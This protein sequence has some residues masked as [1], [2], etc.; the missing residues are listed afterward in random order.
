MM[1]KP[2]RHFWMTV[3][4]ILLITMSCSM[5]SGKLTPIALPEA[6]LEETFEPLPEQTSAPLP[7]DNTPVVASIDNIKVEYVYTT[8]LVTSLYHLYGSLLDHFVD[9]TLTNS[10]SEPVKVIVQTEV[11]GY[12]IQAGDTVNV[13]PGETLELHQDPFL[14][15]EAVDK[16]NSSKPGN[17][18]I[19]VVYLDKGVEKVLLD[20][21]RQILIYARRD[22]VWLPGFTPQE[23]FELW[24]AWV[25][26]NDPGV[27]AL[28]RAAA[29]YDPTGIMTSGYGQEPDDGDG[30]VWR[31]LDA[32]WEAEQKAYNLTYISTMTTFGPN[33]VQRIRLPGEVLDQAS[34]NC[35][36]LAALYASAAEALGLEA[37]II[38]IPGHAYTAIRTDQENAQYYFV[39]TT[40]IGQSSFA[41]AVSQAKIEWE[42]TSPHLDAGEEGYA[43]VTIPTAREKGILPIPWK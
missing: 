13:E 31:R 25:T 30:S 12:T 27:E 38:R 41:D 24:A 39:E 18:H 3:S 14:I 40:M 22:F 43:W 9:I 5:F 8:N 23:E 15:P 28:V 33:S 6:T 1:V 11:A 10:G 32:I 7:I 29:D 37:A 42:E 20:E 16:L 36:E 21:T 2:G 26:P 17:F 19:R 35:I 4:A 34:G